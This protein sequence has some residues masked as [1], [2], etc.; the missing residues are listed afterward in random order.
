MLYPK[1]ARYHMRLFIGDEKFA[2]GHSTGSF[3]SVTRAKKMAAELG[4]SAALKLTDKT[5]A[6][7]I[8][9]KIGLSFIVELSTSNFGIL[10]CG[11][12]EFELFW[13]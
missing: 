2:F 5:G 13:T 6:I 4:K 10:F 9:H 8:L 3:Q 1:A 11:H 12:L 7:A